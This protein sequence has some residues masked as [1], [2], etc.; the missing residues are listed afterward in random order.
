MIRSTDH[1]PKMPPWLP[2]GKVIPKNRARC[3]T[4]ERQEPTWFRQTGKLHASICCRPV[5]IILIYFTTL[6]CWN[7]F[8]FLGGKKLTSIPRRSL[9]NFRN[10]TPMSPMLY[11]AKGNSIPDAESRTGVRA[12][13]IRVFQHRSHRQKWRQEGDRRLKPW[14]LSDGLHA[15]EKQT[16]VANSMSVRLP[17]GAKC[18]K[19][20]AAPSRSRSAKTAEEGKDFPSDLRNRI[21]EGCWL[22]LRSIITLAILMQRLKKKTVCGISDCNTPSSYL[23][24]IRPAPAFISIGFS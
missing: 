6:C 19:R 12:P 5:H 15:Y 10:R 23:E 2:G 3:A 8:P 16:R 4:R 9:F 7:R 11:A 18:A 24:A 14:Y 1:A 13:S 17:L 21:S 22:H 20:Y